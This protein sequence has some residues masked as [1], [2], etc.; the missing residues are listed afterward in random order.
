MIINRKRLPRIIA[1]LRQTIIEISKG[2]NHV[3]EVVVDKLLIEAG[4]IDEFI[5]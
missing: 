1:K 3:S 2:I 4:R 5:F